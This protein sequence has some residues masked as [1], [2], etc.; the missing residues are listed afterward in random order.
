MKK[1]IFILA[2]VVV[3]LLSYAQSVDFQAYRVI[4]EDLKT[5]EV[6]SITPD[7]Y[8]IRIDVKND[9]IGMNNQNKS[10]Y[11][12]IGRIYQV[13]EDGEHRSTGK[14][15][16]IDEEE[17]RCQVLVVLTT[18]PKYPKPRIAIMA[19]YSDSTITWYGELVKRKS[20]RELKKI[21]I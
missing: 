17:I 4:I 19:I 5:D 2:M 12:L 21:E 6:E 14:Y 13:D 15:W 1:V 18:D 16:A 10:A 11:L 8:I 7:P 9:I 3:S 20:D